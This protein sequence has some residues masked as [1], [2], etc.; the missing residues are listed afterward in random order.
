MGLGAELVEGLQSRSTANQRALRNNR[1]QAFISHSVQAAALRDSGRRILRVQKKADSKR[2]IP[3][4][5]RM[6]KDRSFRV[7]R[8]VR[9]RA[10]R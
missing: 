9:Y 4:C 8:I 6:L 3:N 2:K 5:I 10:R 1:Y 7:R